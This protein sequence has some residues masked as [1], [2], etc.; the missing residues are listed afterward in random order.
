MLFFVSYDSTHTTDPEACFIV[1]VLLSCLLARQPRG[2]YFTIRG[3]TVLFIGTAAPGAYFTIG[4]LYLF[5]GR[6]APEACFTIG[7]SYL[8]LARQPRWRALP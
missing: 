5:F 1:E 6:K 3:T 4:V 2:A 7:A 8:F